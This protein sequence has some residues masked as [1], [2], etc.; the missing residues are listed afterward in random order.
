MKRNNKLIS[1]MPGTRSWNV[2]NLVPFHVEELNVLLRRKMSNFVVL[3]NQRVKVE[4]L[5]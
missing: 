4:K 3:Q 1:S 5:V 2:A